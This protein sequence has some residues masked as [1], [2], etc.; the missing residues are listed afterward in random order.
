MQGKDDQMTAE[1]ETGMMHLQAKEWKGF[2]ANM[3][4]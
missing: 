2:L 4:S 1:E 3:R